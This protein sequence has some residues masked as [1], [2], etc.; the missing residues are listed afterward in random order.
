MRSLPLPHPQNVCFYP[1]SAI[2][3]LTD[4]RH[5]KENWTSLKKLVAKRA[6]NILKNGAKSET[7]RFTSSRSMFKSWENKGLI[8]LYLTC[9]VRLAIA[10]KE[11]LLIFLVVVVYKFWY[12]KD[13]PLLLFPFL[14]GYSFFS[15]FHSRMPSIRQK[16]PK[17]YMDTA[18]NSN[19]L[20]KASYE[21]K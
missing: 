3:N 14:L 11:L 1:Q 16:F 10:L 9:F 13:E 2:F 8:I 19:F 18:K 15:S 12:F 21:A 4:F 7:T 20:L 17:T 5:S 6:I